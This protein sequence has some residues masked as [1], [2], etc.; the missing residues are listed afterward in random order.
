[1]PLQICGT[2]ESSRVVVAWMQWAVVRPSPQN[3]V[4][5]DFFASRNED[6]MLNIFSTK[7]T[8]HCYPFSRKLGI[9]KYIREM[10]S[11]SIAVLV[12]S[13]FFVFVFFSFMFRVAYF[14]FCV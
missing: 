8:T 3:E 12:N 6:S 5:L 11:Q 7:L 14:I 4:C 13:V 10:A 9:D 2:L 1:M